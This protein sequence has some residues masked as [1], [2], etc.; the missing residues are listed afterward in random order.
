MDWLMWFVYAIDV[1][2]S[3]DD[4][5]G[6]IAGILILIGGLLVAMALT[7]FDGDAAERSERIVGTIGRRMLYIGVFMALVVL[8]V[9]TKQT[10][11]TML[12]IKAVDVVI[13]TDAV[14]TL[15]PKSVEVVEEYLDSVI[16]D[17]REQNNGNDSIPESLD[18]IKSR[19]PV[20]PKK[21][22]TE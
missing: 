11:Y 19:I 21:L 1:L 20:E 10:M 17:L 22:S 14:Q 3:I 7:A 9:P 2:G 18:D 12:A 16:R 6:F 15:V 13:E 4:S 8:L 5:F